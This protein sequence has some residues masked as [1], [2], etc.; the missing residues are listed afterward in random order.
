MLDVDEMTT[1]LGD[2]EQARQVIIDFQ[3]LMSGAH[4]ID[5][6]SQFDDD[7][8]DSAHIVETNLCTK[9]MKAQLNRLNS[10]ISSIKSSLNVLIAK[11]KETTTTV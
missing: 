9:Q 7:H 10:D 2:K 8:S 5:D 3:F 1:I 4:H 11:N 6:D